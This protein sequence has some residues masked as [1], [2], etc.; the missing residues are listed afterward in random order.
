MHESKLQA[1]SSISG[2]LLAEN[3]RTLLDF[4]TNCQIKSSARKA[5]HNARNIL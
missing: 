2:F 5:H 3:D 4:F 1:F